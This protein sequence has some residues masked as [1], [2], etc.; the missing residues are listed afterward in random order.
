MSTGQ[1][2]SITNWRKIRA[3]SFARAF[4]F[5]GSEL[6]V[7]ALILREKDSGASTVSI[8]LILGMM[9]LILFAPW[10]G[11][12]ADKFSTKQVVQTSSL[13][14]AVLVFSLTIDG[15]H[16]LVFATLF[17]ANT[18]GSTV[19]PSWGALVPTLCT[20][21]DLPRALG[22]S[23]SIFALAGLFAPALAG[24]LVSTSGFYWPFVIDA[25]TFL[26]IATMPVVLRVNRP[27][28]VEVNGQKSGAMEGIN[29]LF[30][31]PLLR[32][33]LI[34][35]TIFILALGAVNVGEVFLVTEE[36]GAS[37]F[38]YGLVGTAF[39]L[40]AL[41]GSTGS[42]SAKIPET[43][44]V[45]IVILGL[46][47]LSVA[48]LGIASAWHWGVVLAFSLLAGI[49]N[50]IINAYAVGIFINR[51]EQ[52]IQ[53]R[54]LAG[55]SGVINAGSIVAMSIAGVTI[56]VFGVREVLFAGGLLSIAVLAILAPSVLRHAPRV[57]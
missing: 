26:F 56:G 35:L 18:C 41:L 20:R 50:S 22:F 53:G 51:S 45:H 6:T 36:L 38:I 27:R 54:I 44:H 55:V 23:Q 32:A 10:A 7:F 5:L 42:A 40:G 31:E 21:E 11:L 14:Q 25:I 12:I 13:I 43:R 30:R 8:L 4:S 15:P 2:V 46:I 16:W 47:L 52:A 19:N 29:Y 39:A 17:L 37:Y 49:G 1:E 57:A 28:T 24:L 33:L 3:I 34:L 48:V 9:P